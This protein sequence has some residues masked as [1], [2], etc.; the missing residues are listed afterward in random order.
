MIQ[1]VPPANALALL[2]YGYVLRLQGKLAEA[3]PAYRRALALHPRDPRVQLN[4]AVFLDLYRQRPAEALPLFEGA[5]KARAEAGEAED[6]LLNGW[7]AELRARLGVKPSPST[8][9]TP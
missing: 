8:G 6:R 9:S 3:E 7:I 5:A 1:P 4:A 2:E